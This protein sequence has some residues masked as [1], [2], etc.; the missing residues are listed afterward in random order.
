ME[1]P[2]A[3][4]ISKDLHSCLEDAIK[5]ESEGWNLAKNI[6]KCMNDFDEWVADTGAALDKSDNKALFNRPMPPDLRNFIATQLTSLA[7]ASERQHVSNGL[8]ENFRKNGQNEAAD[9]ADSPATRAAAVENIL[10]AQNPMFDITTAI[11][12][13]RSKANEIPKAN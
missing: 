9:S 3:K 10:Q 11:E 7:T 2:T 8:V 1:I 4:I 6:K 13:L 12:K 5:L